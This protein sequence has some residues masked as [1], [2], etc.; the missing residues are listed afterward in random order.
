MAVFSA[1]VRPST[2]SMIQAST[3]LFSPKPG[4]MNLPFSSLRNQFTW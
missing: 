4:Q 2:R 3:R 1:S